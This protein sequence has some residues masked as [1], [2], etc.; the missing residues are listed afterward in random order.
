MAKRTWYRCT[1]GFESYDFALM[2][3]HP[4]KSLPPKGFVHGVTTYVDSYVHADVN[5]YKVGDSLGVIVKPR[6]PSPTD[7]PVGVYDSLN[8]G[9]R[10]NFSP[11][12]EPAQPRIF[13]P[14]R[15]ADLLSLYDT[16]KVI[17]SP[18]LVPEDDEFYR[19]PG[20]RSSTER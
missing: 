11:S 13:D 5:T 14:I 6:L 15:D 4:H 9:N 7:K 12:Q 10:L 3:G 8:H 2:E 18:A 16:F 19:M 17:P 1:C 20:Y